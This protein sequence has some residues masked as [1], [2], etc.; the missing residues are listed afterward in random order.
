MVGK[1]SRCEG[2]NRGGDGRCGDA[3][4]ERQAVV[5]VTGDREEKDAGDK[6]GDG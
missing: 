4:C 5:T 3:Q 1:M 2:D 6:R